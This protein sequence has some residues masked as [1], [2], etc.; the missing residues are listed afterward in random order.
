MISS[1]QLDMFARQA[2]AD[3]LQN[4]VPLNDSITKIAEE[5]ALNKEQVA[6]VIEAANTST[7][8]DLF[9]KSADKY[10]QFPPADPSKIGTEM[11]KVA[12]VSASDYSLEPP[13]ETFEI[14]ENT[15]FEKVAEVVEERTSE[16]LM[17]DYYRF[18]AAEAQLDNMLMEEN[19]VFESQA[20]QLKG[21]IKQAVLSGT[22]YTDVYSALSSV[23]QDP[24]FKA[25]LDAIEQELTPEMPINSLIKTAQV[26]KGTVNGKH[27]LIKKAQVLVELIKD[28]IT[29]KE[30]LAEVEE[31]WELYKQG[32][33][34]SAFK[35]VAQHPKPALIG[36]GLGA[37]ATAV[38]M[39]IVAKDANQR[40]NSVLKTIPQGYAL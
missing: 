3:Y 34:I 31:N 18:K 2:V 1:Y 24:I 17:R 12:E 4:Q 27:P 40:K 5:H 7:Y 30:K 14:P 33:V 19:I 29:L 20:N 9:E 6:R 8:L 23:S 36:L 32:G 28:Y 21:L 11:P 37:A 16:Q 15:G 10:V 38:T 26:H 13:T 25:T 22:T 35:T 39:P